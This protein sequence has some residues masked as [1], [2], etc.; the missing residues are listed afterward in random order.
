[1]G[2]VWPP[3][4]RGCERKIVQNLSLFSRPLWQIVEAGFVIT[5]A[6]YTD[7]KE[8]LALQKLSYKK[9]AIRYNDF[10]IQPLTQ[11]MEEIREEF[12]ISLFLKMI[13]ADN[14]IIGSVRA[15]KSSDTVHI[16][17]LIVHPDHQRKGYAKQLMKEVESQFASDPEIE[18]F[19]LFTGDLSEDNIALYESI[20]YE[21]YHRESRG[22]VSFVFMEKKK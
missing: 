8:I 16:G 20:G 2:I 21:V 9:E 15:K 22:R 6:E 18:R 7:L 10:E 12:E 13:L 5:H 19:E 14:Q 4:L 17:K 1:M 3:R 11:T